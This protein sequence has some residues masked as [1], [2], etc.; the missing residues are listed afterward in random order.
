MNDPL[1]SGFFRR[2]EENLRVPHRFVM[3][4]V[5]G[6]ES[7]PISINE[8]IHSLQRF[9]EPYRLVEMKRDA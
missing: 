8:R 6:V 3:G 2:L 5:L 4:K 9:P 1:H 7:D